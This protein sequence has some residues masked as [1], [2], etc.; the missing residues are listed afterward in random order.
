MHVFCSCLPEHRCVSSGSW[1]L[2]AAEHPYG[3]VGAAPHKQK[4][5]PG[6]EA[7]DQEHTCN[8]GALG[9]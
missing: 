8:T 3:S 2:L 5:W 1:Q 6:L 4:P 7:L 9:A